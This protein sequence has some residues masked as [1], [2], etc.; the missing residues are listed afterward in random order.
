MFTE[1]LPVLDW[2]PVVKKPYGTELILDLH[3]CDLSVFNR[4]S[5]E[6]YLVDI[7]KLIDM[8]R[9]GKPMFWFDKSG[10]EHLNGVSA[11][12]FIETSTIVI[13]GMD[14]MKTVLINIFSCKMFDEHL[15]AAFT[16][17]YFKATDC[18]ARIVRRY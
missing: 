17:T 15:A 16:T 7:C 18:Q 6:K 10:V 4:T 9:H 1:K 13:H 3:G 12:Q 5:L 2:A 14:L 11:V 8:K